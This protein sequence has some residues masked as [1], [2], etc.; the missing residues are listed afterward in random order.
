MTLL[1]PVPKHGLYVQW[2]AVELRVLL[3]ALGIARLLV[4]REVHE[5]DAVVAAA[6]VRRDLDAEVAEAAELVV[7]GVAHLAVADRV[8][9]ILQTDGRVVAGEAVALRVVELVVTAAAAI[10]LSLSVSVSLVLT[11]AFS[12]T[13]SVS[14]A[15]ALLFSVS[16]T[17]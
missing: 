17:A 6:L 16:V 1:R 10:S 8:V 13:L 5:G 9:Q 11:V 7:D 3:E 14:L 2:E 4:S 15:V 12:A